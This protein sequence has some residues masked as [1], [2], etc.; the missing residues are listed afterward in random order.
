MMERKEVIKAVNKFLLP[1]SLRNF[2]YDPK[3]ELKKS[4]VQLILD[5]YNQVAKM[6]LPDEKAKIEVK[7]YLKPLEREQQFLRDNIRR[8][9]LKL[10]RVLSRHGDFQRLSF[11]GQRF[12][13]A[14]LAK[15]AEDKGR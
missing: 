11:E 15:V 1:G 6:N 13:V 5:I 14:Y 7:N 4:Y 3:S 10:W 8:E 12:F 9:T 2:N